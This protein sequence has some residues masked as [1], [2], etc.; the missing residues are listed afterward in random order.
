MSVYPQNTINGLNLAWSDVNV[1]YKP[2][3]FLSSF[4]SRKKE[5]K[6]ILKHQNGKI[7]SGELIGLLGSSGSGMLK[8]EFNK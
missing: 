3:T 5:E 6:D 1:V 8:F 7:S 2:N 4:L